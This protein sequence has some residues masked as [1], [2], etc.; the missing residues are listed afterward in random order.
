MSFSSVASD[1]VKNES[2]TIQRIVFPVICNLI[3]KENQG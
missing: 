2:K 3:R 1:E